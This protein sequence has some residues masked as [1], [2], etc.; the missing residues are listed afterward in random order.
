MM[1]TPATTSPRNLII[2]V[3]V[4]ACAAL[5]LAVLAI[6]LLHPPGLNSDFMAFWS[7]PRFAATHPIA[8]IYDAATLQSFQQTLYPGFHSFYP[9]LYPPTFLLP[10]W[11]LKFF[12]FTAAQWLWTLSGLALFTAATF[13]FFPR[14]RWLMLLALLASPASLLCGVTGETAYFT[15]ALLLFGFAALPTRPL[16]AGLAFGLLTLKPPLGVLIP[17][18]LLA[19]GDWRAILAA[20]AT[21]LGLVALSCLAFPPSLWLLWAHTLPTYQTQYFTGHGLNLNI[22]VTPAANLV[23]LGVAPAKAWLVQTLCS[24]V[25]A[26]LVFLT[27]RRRASYPLAVAVLLTGSF[28]AVPHA[29]AYDSITLTAAMALCLTTKT[30][31]WQVLLG[32][33]VYLAP[34]MLLSPAAHWFLYSLPETLLF[35]SIVALALRSSASNHKSVIDAGS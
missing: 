29:Y 11:W 34:L 20:S 4:A 21:A 8:Q 10:S 28:L 23:T 6:C 9:Y 33:L 19:R 35:A 24:I 27:A 5:N 3:V 1:P 25:I 31:L 30:P 26:A 17:F 14:R 15:S 32:C 2:A 16:L 18:F 22:I 7:F 13:A 12:S